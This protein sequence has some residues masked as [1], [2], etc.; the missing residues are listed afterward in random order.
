MIGFLRK[1]V[2]QRV[3]GNYIEDVMKEGLPSEFGKNATA[4]YLATLSRCR[5][6]YIA[7][8]FGGKRFVRSSDAGRTGRDRTLF[9]ALVTVM[10]ASLASRMGIEKKE[11][12][13]VICWQFESIPEIWRSHL[14]GLTEAL[15]DEA[16]D[17]PFQSNSILTF[18]RQ[19]SIQGST[20]SEDL[21]ILEGMTFHLIY[22]AYATDALEQFRRIRTM[23]DA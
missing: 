1:K 20:Q 16:G 18:M 13:R 23:L 9:A 15:V 5:F 19:I 11:I 7:M 10:F 21:E 6:L 2:A 12:A 14:I 4:G 22:L 3:V 8:F 17:L